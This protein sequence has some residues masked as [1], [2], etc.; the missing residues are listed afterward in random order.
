MGI[1]VA[2]LGLIL[3]AS[4]I[5]AYFAIRSTIAP[6]YSY[7]HISGVLSYFE[8][9]AMLDAPSIALTLLGL[10]SYVAGRIEFWNNEDNHRIAQVS[11]LTLGGFILGI[12]VFFCLAVHSSTAY[13]S[14]KLWVPYSDVLVENS[15]GL[16]GAIFWV[17][18]GIVILI[19]C[20]FK[21]D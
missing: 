14:S 1:R 2:K 16:L 13:Y 4:S 7:L 18:A 12:G 19:D 6:R 3:L 20:C 21:L 15:T 17:I 10:S 11:A 8:W 9:L 5:F